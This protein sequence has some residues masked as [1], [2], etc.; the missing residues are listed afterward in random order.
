MKETEIC[1]FCNGEGVYDSGGETPW[2][3]EILIGCEVCKGSGELT[4]KEMKKERIIIEEQ[5]KTSLI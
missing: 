4:L 3:T 1:P 5:I 2:G